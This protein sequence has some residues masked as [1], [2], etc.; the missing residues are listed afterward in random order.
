ME[1]DFQL[2]IIQELCN[3]TFHV[4]WLFATPFLVHF[5]SF[6]GLSLVSFYYVLFHFIYYLALTPQQ[7]FLVEFK[8]MLVASN[9]CIWPE[10]LKKWLLF[11]AHVASEQLARISNLSFVACL[12][13]NIVC[14]CQYAECFYLVIGLFDK[15]MIID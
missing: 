7:V 5:I 11:F 4:A 9:N 1:C 10:W 2:F 14:H 3:N 8:F 12:K 15:V 6:L 13:T